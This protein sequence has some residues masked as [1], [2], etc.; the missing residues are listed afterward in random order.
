VQNSIISNQKDR[1]VAY[2]QHFSWGNAMNLRYAPVCDDAMLNN[3]QEGVW[4]PNCSKTFA[5]LQKKINHPQKMPSYAPAAFTLDVL[6][7]I[8]CKT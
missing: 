1:K 6:Y 8:F 3:I 2:F 4:N 7:R 5:S